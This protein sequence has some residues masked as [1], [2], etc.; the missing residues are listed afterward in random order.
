M[1][2]EKEKIPGSI[3]DLIK[4]IDLKNVE[5]TIEDFGIIYK[6]KEA[7][8]QSHID[9]IEKTYDGY[10]EK[11]KEALSTLEEYSKLNFIWTLSRPMILIIYKAWTIWLP[12]SRR[13][14][15]R[16]FRR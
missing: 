8:L 7:E 13:V 5:K 2:K 6:K 9:N 3:F 11:I 15:R 4:N 10:K 1:K 12:I 14:C 16:F